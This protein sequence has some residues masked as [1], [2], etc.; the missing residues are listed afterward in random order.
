MERKVKSRLKPL[1]Q[2]NDE[3]IMGKYISSQ[4]E[5]FILAGFLGLKILDFDFFFNRLK[6]EEFLLSKAFLKF[7]QITLDCK[8]LKVAEQGL[9]LA[10]LVFYLKRLD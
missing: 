3:I 2:M 1:G 6:K 5:S 10:C 9:G 8:A 7:H 4:V